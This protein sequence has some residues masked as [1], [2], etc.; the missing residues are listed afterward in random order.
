M[1]A[2]ADLALESRVHIAY[3]RIGISR[4]LRLAFRTATSNKAKIPKL[5]LAA[6]RRNAPN[7]SLL[8]EEE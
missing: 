7:E 4:Y 6:G 2:Q 8:R 3:Y 5:L 1:Q